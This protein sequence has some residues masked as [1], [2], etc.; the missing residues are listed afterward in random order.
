MKEAEE[1]LNTGGQGA[2]HQSKAR[3]AKILKKET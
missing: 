1:R 2:G 3:F